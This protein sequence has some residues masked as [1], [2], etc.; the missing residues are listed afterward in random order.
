M[1]KPPRSGLRLW[2]RGILLVAWAVTCG[3]VYLLGFYTGKGTQERQLGL[4]E[5][6][7]RL[8]VTSAPPPEGQRPKGNNELTFYEKLVT[9]AGDGGMAPKPAPREA[10]AREPQPTPPAAPAAAPD[11][12]APAKPAATAKPA[13][14]AAVPAK[15]ATVAPSPAVTT[16]AAKPAPTAAP[17]PVARP[18][19]TATTQPPARQTG[20]WTVEANP[21]RNRAEVDDLLYR[22]RGRGYQASVSQVQREGDTWYRL[23]VGRYATPEQANEVMRRLREQEG[24]A[25]A[26]VASD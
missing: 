23:R 16:G 26:F 24:V 8:P 15:V 7:V 3:L 22:L 25:H 13:P 9:G 5:R 4:E 2:E 1:A 21:T 20:G 12:A 18:A 17:G 11:A 14:P 19:T 6:V 10:P